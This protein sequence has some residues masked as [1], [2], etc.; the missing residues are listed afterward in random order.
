MA[1]RIVIIQGHPDPQGNRYGH[2]L[3]AAYAEGAQAAGHEVR[4]IDIAGLDFALLR[5]QAEFENG[6]PPPSIRACQDD[7]RWADHLAIFYPLWH[8]TMPALLKGFFEQVMR[9]G[10]AYI[11]PES[12]G[13]WKKLLKGKSARVVIT[14]GMP[15]F[16]YRWYFRAHSLKSLERNILGFVGIGPVRESLV[17]MVEGLGGTKR[18]AWLE[19]MRALGRAGR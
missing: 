11:L 8:G 14:M 10:F 15:A 1:R 7:L 2:A 12:G 4:R 19:K 16:W 17:G 18:K 3:A 13:M 9:P 5:T 6:E